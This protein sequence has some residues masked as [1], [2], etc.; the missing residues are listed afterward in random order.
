MLTCEVIVYKRIVSDRN[1]L[2]GITEVSRYQM[3]D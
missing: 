1:K 2:S 3:C